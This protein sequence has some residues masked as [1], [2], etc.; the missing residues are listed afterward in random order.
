[1]R[2]FHKYL[3]FNPGM[4]KCELFNHCQLAGP[5]RM[6]E[7]HDLNLVPCLREDCGMIPLH[8]LMDHSRSSHGYQGMVDTQLRG[9]TMIATVCWNYVTEPDCDATFNCCFIL[10]NSNYILF[11]RLIKSQGYYHF[12]LK[13]LATEEVSSRLMV[14]IEV[15]NRTGKIKLS[16]LRVYPIEYGWEDVKLHCEGM[17]SIDTNLAQRFLV[18]QRS[19]ITQYRVGPRSNAQ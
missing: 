7:D 2:G 8:Q 14:E 13:M 10:S 6:L 18:G 19:F 17:L 5:D 12:Y 11:P 9:G 1:M 16:E 15:G 4:R 3:F